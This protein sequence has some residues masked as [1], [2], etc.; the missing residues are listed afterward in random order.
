MIRRWRWRNGLS[1]VSFDALVGRIETW[2]PRTHSWRSF[3]RQSF[4]WLETPGTYPFLRGV[5]KLFFFLSSVGN[6]AAWNV[7]IVRM[8][9]DGKGREGFWACW[10]V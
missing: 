4:A 5:G 7:G 10:V 8:G 9:W 3:M 1:L 6:C 2:L